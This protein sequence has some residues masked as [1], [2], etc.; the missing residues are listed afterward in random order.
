[1]AYA[2]DIQLMQRE[3]WPKVRA[4]YGDGLATGLAAFMSAPPLWESFDA[5]HLAVGRLVARH[6]DKVVGWTALSRAADT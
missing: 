1:M 2:V 4:I 5:S 3:D 6:G